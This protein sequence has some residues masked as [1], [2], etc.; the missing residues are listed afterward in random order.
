MDR[1]F[2]R[3]LARLGNKSLGDAIF[4]NNFRNVLKMTYLIDSKIN[5]IK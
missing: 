3:Q 4:V 1:E 5:I 2:Q